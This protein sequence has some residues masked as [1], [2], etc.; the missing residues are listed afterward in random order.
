MADSP[1]QFPARGALPATYPPDVKTASYPAEP[2][3]FLFESPCRSLQQIAIVRAG[4]VRG[5]FTP[6]RNDWSHLP[7]TRRA[8]TE[9][10]DLHVLGL[11]DSIVNDTMRSGWLASLREAYPQAK[12][13]GTVYVRG[14]GGCHHYKEKGRIGQYLLP[15]KPDLVFIGGISQRDIESIREVIRQVRA[16]LPDAE[17]LLATGPFGSADPRTPEALKQIQDPAGYAASL[18]TLA[19]ETR[20]AFLDMRTPWIEY[21][22]SAKVHPHLF[23]RDP[24]H[25]NESGE[26]ILAKI[27]MAFFAPE[28]AGRP[29]GG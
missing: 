6:P 5:E 16:G 24:V 2:D 11:G 9:G 28:S 3:Y 19:A 25:A 10:G 18:K 22:R 27:L 14:G 7:R 12:I 29:G 26:Q 23:Y 1:V 21:L 13:R 8:L 15:L 4:M 20:C 17:C